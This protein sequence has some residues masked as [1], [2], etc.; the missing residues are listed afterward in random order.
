MPE[1]SFICPDRTEGQINQFVKVQG[2][3]PFV[4]FKLLRI[5]CL[6]AFGLRS[7]VGISRSQY[8]EDREGIKKVNYA[9]LYRFS[10]LKALKCLSIENSCSFFLMQRAAMMLSVEGTV[11][12]FNLSRP[13]YSPAFL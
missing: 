12:P 5:S 8:R 7:R 2:Q 4:K 1:K 13:I 11:M 9:G 6:F 3:E 10:P